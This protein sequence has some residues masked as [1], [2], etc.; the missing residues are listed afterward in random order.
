MSAGETAAIMIVFE[1]PPRAFCSS[2]VRT[3]SRYGTLAFFLFPDE[4][5]ARAVITL[6]S[7]DNDLLMAAPELVFNP[8][9]FCKAF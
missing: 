4:L 6:P 7:A 9:A 1:L 8:W 5:S 2:F 3:E